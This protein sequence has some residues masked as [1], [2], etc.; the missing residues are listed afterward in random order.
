[1]LLG[2]ISY[3]SYESRNTMRLMAPI[4]EKEHQSST[5]EDQSA[6]T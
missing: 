5:D 6:E 4:E 3:T 2:L 1:M